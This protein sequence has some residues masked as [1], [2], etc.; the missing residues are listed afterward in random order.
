MRYDD[1][2]GMRKTVIKKLGRKVN[3]IVPIPGYQTSL[4]A[5]GEL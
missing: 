2:T 1:Y 4:L 5:G 3:E